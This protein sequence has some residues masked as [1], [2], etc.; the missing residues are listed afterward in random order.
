MRRAEV[1]VVGAGEGSL[2]SLVAQDARE[3][4]WDVL[5]AGV[6]TEEFIFNV[7]APLASWHNVMEVVKPTVVIY[8]PGYNSSG[9]GVVM[10]TEA[11]VHMQIHLYGLLKCAEAFK[12]RGESGLLLDQMIVVSSNSARIPRS[13]SVGYCAAKAAQSMAVRVLARR[14]KGDPLVYGYEPGLMYT[15]SSI[16]AV[17]KEAYGDK[18]A[19]RMVGV[20]KYG[21]SPTTLASLIVANMAADYRPLNGCLIPFDAGEL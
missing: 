1:L 6:T 14:W 17:G 19:H 15:Q 7:M 10:A 5:T 16:I 18:P 9:T 21:L 20:G 2:G 11:E 12:A 4:G 13:P 8:A 3:K